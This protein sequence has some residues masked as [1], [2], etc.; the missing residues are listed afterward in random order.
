MIST[1]L[2]A[3]LTVT[4]SE[5]DSNTT[6]TSATPSARSIASPTYCHVGT[7]N[8][9]PGRPC[10]SVPTTAKGDNLILST[11]LASMYSPTT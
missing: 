7:V 4:V 2:A 8:V 10:N 1:D 9:L 11:N 3:F 5:S 6:G